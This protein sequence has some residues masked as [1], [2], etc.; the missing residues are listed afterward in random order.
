[1]NQ[2]PIQ[3]IA[4]L[5]PTF[6]DLDVG[7]IVYNPNYM[8][9]CD[10]ARNDFYASRGEHVM[11]M[12]EKDIVFAVVACE[13]KYQKPLFLE[14]YKMI[15]RLTGSSDKCLFFEH[16]IADPALP[17]HDLAAPA[18]EKVPDLRFFARYTLVCV[19]LQ[20]KASQIIPEDF[21]LAVTGAGK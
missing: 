6:D 20:R 5:H 18:L 15:T 13:L 14:S 1:M 16:A 11:R 12:M 2:Q 4:P 8:I 21:R 10:R 9:Y 3:L 19:S 17:D 7:G